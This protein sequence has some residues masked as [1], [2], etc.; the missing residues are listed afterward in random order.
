MDDGWRIFTTIH[1]FTNR[2]TD[3]RRHI[4]TSMFLVIDNNE[5]VK[6]EL[7]WRRCFT[8]GLFGF[9]GGDTV[10][11]WG[12]GCETGLSLSALVPIRRVLRTRD[13][14]RGWIGTGVLLSEPLRVICV[15]CCT[16]GRR[17]GGAACGLVG[18]TMEL[19]VCGSTTD[20]VHRHAK[21]HR[22]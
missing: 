7:S 15:V 9:A 20:G 2:K 10:S 4:P 5:G 19:D 14:A 8:H 21:H 3:L 16:L 18:C 13:F 22:G 17:V 12:R 6:H 1:G 11:C